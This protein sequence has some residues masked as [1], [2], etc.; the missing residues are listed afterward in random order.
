[1]TIT[2]FKFET[3]KH[4]EY[5][6]SLT[7]QK[8]SLESCL[9]D[10]MKMSGL[11]WAVTSAFLLHKE[12]EVFH[13]N[14]RIL[15]FVEHCFDEKSGGYAGNVGHDGHLLYT[16]H[17]ILILATMRALDRIPSVSRVSHFVAKH[18]LEDGSFGGDAG[19]EIDTKF[20]YCALS[21]LSI[22]KQRDLI[23]VP[24]AMNFIRSCRNFDGGFGNLPGCE[25]HGGHIF[26]AV[27]SL[28]FGK[29]INENTV[30]C[31]ALGWWLS[32]RQCDSG[33][34]N[35]RP[36]KQADVCY[37][38][39]NISVLIMLHK[40]EWID[41]KKLILFILNCQDTEDGGIA[42][43]PGNVADVYHTFFG[44]GGLSLLGYFD[45][46]EVQAAHPEVK[47]FRRIHP[48][49]AIP[50]DVVEELKLEYALL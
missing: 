32:E 24:K 13:V 46:P 26:T 40:L 29:S 3:A 43:R 38:W 12:S 15:T 22:L 47:N 42:D 7:H 44:I 25:S 41:K 23:S 36:E 28:A 8:P 17:A 10:H 21:V 20:T 45:D 35:G 33:G 34:L 16:C 4:V 31:T 19:M 48:V 11:Y 27:G 2:S 30:D 9:T 49:F 37:S 1:M 6:Q 39:W 14:D 18:Q 50:S 5:L